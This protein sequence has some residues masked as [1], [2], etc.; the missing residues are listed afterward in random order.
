MRK[1]RRAIANG[2]TFS[3]KLGAARRRGWISVNERGGGT[4]AN[5]AR[6][7]HPSRGQVTVLFALLLTSMLGMIAVV[8]DVGYGMVQRRIAQNL[9]DATATAGSQTIGNN[10]PPVVTVYN[11][12]VDYAIS[13]VVTA[14]N[15]AAPPIGT[16]AGTTPSTIYVVAQYT[17]TSGATISGE[18]VGTAH[19]P[20][21]TSANGVKSTVTMTYSTF[22]ARAIGVS[23]VTVSATATAI[24]RHIIVK[25]ATGMN[26]FAARWDPPFGTTAAAAFATA[27][28]PTG[29]SPTGCK[30]PSTSQWQC[31]SHLTWQD[32]GDSPNPDAIPSGTS[33]LVYDNGQTWNNTNTGGPA[34]LDWQGGASNFKGFFNNLVTD[35]VLGNTGNGVGSSVGQVPTNQFGVAFFPLVD[36][37][38]GNGA[39]MQVHIYGLIG[40]KIT[41]TSNSITG[42][43]PTTV[44][45]MPVDTLCGPTQVDSTGKSQFVG[46]FLIN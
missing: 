3:T 16:S 46:A 29:Y 28:P 30:N 13:D 38:T 23:Q 8:T 19:L 14:A 22:F 2:S 42:F 5:I 45:D 26:P 36:W 12:T 20:V 24:N 39:N 17:A 25:G 40:L 7:G 35:C 15:F 27:R 1:A 18:Y 6:H 32:Q 33:F 41:Q 31:Y 44:G 10:A 4:H 9:A 11:D 21:D 34:D 43:K 37:S